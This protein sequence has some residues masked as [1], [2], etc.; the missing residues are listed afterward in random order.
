MGR[1]HPD[2]LSGK[3]APQHRMFWTLLLIWIATSQAAYPQNNIVS[4]NTGSGQTLISEIRSFFVGTGV[5]QPL[6]S[7]DL[8]FATDEQPTPGTFLDSFTVSIQ[9]NAQ[10]FSAV[11][12]T[13]DGSGAQ[14]APPSPGALTLD[15]A[16]IARIP[17]AYPDLQPSL[18]QQTAFEVTAPIPSEF[19]GSTVNVFFEFFDH[20]DSTPSQVWF[21]D[22]RVVSVPEPQTW[23]LLLVGGG[24]LW[25]YRR[26]RS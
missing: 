12:L 18:P 23:A 20:Q 8:G 5:Q 17:I 14:W 1:P 19:E 10:R 25:C 22:V 24:G 16:S 15:S 4:H 6:L 9:D 11:Y 3:P 13:I 26:R 7:F 2:R 21:S